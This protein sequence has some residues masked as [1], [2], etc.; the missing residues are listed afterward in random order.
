MRLYSHNFLI[1]LFSTA[2]YFPAALF[3]DGWS[4]AG[5]KALFL[6][7]HLD[8]QVSVLVALCDADAGIV[9]VGV[10]DVGLVPR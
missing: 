7:E 1:I 3:P 2:A 5:R 9:I 6:D 10:Q 4:G 8:K